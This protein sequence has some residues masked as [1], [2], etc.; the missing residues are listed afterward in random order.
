MGNIRNA[1]FKN[2]NITNMANK[3]ILFFFSLK[4][5]ESIKQFGAGPLAQYHQECTIFL[6]QPLSWLEYCCRVV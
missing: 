3:Y 4:S 6:C 2:E 1:L 5:S